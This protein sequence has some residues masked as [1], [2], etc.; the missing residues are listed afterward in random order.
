MTGFAALTREAA[1]SGVTHAFSLGFP[2]LSVALPSRTSRTRTRTRGLRADKHGKQHP[3]RH[4]SPRSCPAHQ[5][6]WVAYS[7]VS[8]LCPVLVNRSDRV[9]GT[10]SPTDH[11]Q[12]DKADQADSRSRFSQ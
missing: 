11:E 6:S 7:Q 2:S 1:H 9:S 12:V 4:T 5:P 8:F 3:Y 10:Y